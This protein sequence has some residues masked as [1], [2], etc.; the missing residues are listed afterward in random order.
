MR[1]LLTSVTLVTFLLTPLFGQTSESESQSQT[2]RAAS[3]AEA[4]TPAGSALTTIFSPA[5]APKQKT[6]GLLQRSFLDLADQGDQELEVAIVVDGTDSMATELAGVRQNVNQMLDDLRRVRNNE[7]RA[8]IVVYRDAG[9]PTDEVEIPLGNFTSDKATIAKAVESLQPASGA[10]Y[11]HELPDLGLQHAMEKLPWSDDDQVTKWILLFGDAPPYSE[12]I[13][14]SQVPEARRRVATANL[15]ATARRKNIRINC[16]LCTSSD[17]VSEP[18]DKAIDE[19]RT[20]MN[21]LAGG[22][23]EGFRR[24]DKLPA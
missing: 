5:R 16:V 3:S 6:M 7:V 8:A 13:D 15:I 1:H 20:F 4:L 2:D 19:T 9:S 18:Y 21:A 24:R 14:N 22:T 10:P 12:T 11:F 17:N 23:D